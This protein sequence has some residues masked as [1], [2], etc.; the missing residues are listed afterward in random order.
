MKVEDFTEILAGSDN[1]SL[2]GDAVQHGLKDREVEMVFRRKTDQHESPV[3]A[4]AV[5]GLPA[6]FGAGRSNDCLMS[7][8]KFLEKSN[9]VV[10]FCVDDVRRTQFSGH[11]KLRVIHVHGHDFGTCYARILNGHVPQSTHAKHCENVRWA[12]T[13]NLYRFVRCHAS[14]GQRGGVEGV[15]P[16]GDGNHKI[17][18]GKDVITVTTIDAISGVFL[19]ETKRLPPRY[20]L[21]A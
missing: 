10:R 19:I 12:G 14:T 3:S 5:V 11:F 20:T 17:T 7:S 16:I 18:V 2:D 15:H 8:S 13:R 21:L 9:G 6:W 4:K 1:R